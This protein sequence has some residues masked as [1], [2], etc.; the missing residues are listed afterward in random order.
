MVTKVFFVGNIFASDDGIG[1]YLY[2]Q[3]KD[4]PRL[5]HCEL[6]EA[7]IIGFDMISYINESDTVIV[8][9]AIKSNKDAGS[10]I[11]IG[12]DDEIL[13]AQGMKLV[14][15]HDFGVE[16]TAKVLRNYMPELKKI[17]VIGISVKDLQPFS[18]KLSEELLSK[19]EIIKSEVINMINELS[20]D[21]SSK[22]A[23][24]GSEKV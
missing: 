24:I 19:S 4:E 12:E 8:V 10:V 16:Q 18:M 3:L 5:K 15:A 23:S 6:I 2:S 9:D 7:G 1:P 11:L 17:W 22:A 14:S 20:S 13:S 21:G